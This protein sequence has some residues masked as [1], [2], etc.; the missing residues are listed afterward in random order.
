MA[1]NPVVPTFLLPRLS[2]TRGIPRQRTEA[3]ARFRTIPT[4]SPPTRP[5][6]SQIHQLASASI[7]HD[8]RKLYSVS[9]VDRRPFSTTQVRPRDHHFDTL[10]FVQRLR[11]EGFSEDQSKAMMLVLSDVIEE[12]IQNL[13]RTMVPKE[14]EQCFPTCPFHP[15]HQLN[16]PPPPPPYRSRPL[17]LHPKSRLHETALR[18]PGARL[19]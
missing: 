4:S 10:K 6:R 7:R 9:D 5:S 1:S 18:A 11:D 2:W 12:S 17:H 19:Q 15:D 3:F 14:G 16:T 13:T 8:R